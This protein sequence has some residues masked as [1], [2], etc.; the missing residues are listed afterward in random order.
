M[1]VE[2]IQLPVGED[3]VSGRLNVPNDDAKRGDAERGIVLLPGAGHGPYGD[4]FDQFADTATEDGHHVLRFQ[5]WRSPDELWEKTLGELHAEIDAAVA[6]LQDSGCSN[7]S[8]VAKSFCG[9][10]SLTHVP[11][12]IERMVLWAPAIRVGEQ[13][14]IEEIETTKLSEA[15]SMQIDDATLAAIETPTLILHGDEDEGVPIEGSERMVEH[16]QDARLAVIEGTD[17]SFLG[18]DPRE[19][20]VEKTA[21]F[22]SNGL[23]CHS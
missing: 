15:E 1:S 23:R 3:S 7:V 11:D 14:T 17:H 20:T 5:S 9:G 22:L 12:A 6:F 18:T 19:E 13:A 10:V 16:M 8:L 2:E 4:I 21:A